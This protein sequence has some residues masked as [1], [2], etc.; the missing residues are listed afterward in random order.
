MLYVFHGQDLKTAVEKAHALA[1]SLR[2]KKPDASFVE[3]DGDS[4]NASALEGHLGGQGLF[5]SKYIVFL[6]RVTEN[7]EAKDALASFA[8]AMK[9]SPNIFIVLEG[10]LNAELK[11]AFDKSAEKTVECEPKA[12][13]KPRFEFNVFAIAGAVGRKDAV[14]AWKAYREAIDGGIEPENIAGVL[15]WKAKSTMDKVLARKLITS[16]HDSH[17]G[18]CDLELSLER[19]LLTL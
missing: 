19:E 15:F 13:A 11:R 17:R 16:Y 9:G 2:A 7:A 3:M 10:K 8:S 14:G 5:S 1:N 18:L 12:A 4:W 6:N